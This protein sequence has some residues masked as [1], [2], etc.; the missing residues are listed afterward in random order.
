MYMMTSISCTIL[1]QSFFFFFNDTAT[2]EIYTLFLHDALPIFCRWIVL[3][4]KRQ[5]PLESMS[6]GLQRQELRKQSNFIGRISGLTKTPRHLK[7]RMP[8]LK[9]TACLLHDIGSSDVPF[10][11]F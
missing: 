6:R 8:M 2:T 10:R 4:L 7:A 9:P 1:S 3:F 5:N 11:Y